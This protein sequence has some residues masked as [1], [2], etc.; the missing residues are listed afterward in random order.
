MNRLGLVILVV[1]GLGAHLAMAQVAQDCSSNA[2]PYLQK[3]PVE[4][5][6]T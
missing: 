6:I 1:F 5:L 4:W 3:Q 2:L